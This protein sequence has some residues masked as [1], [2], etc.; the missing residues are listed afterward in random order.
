VE[1]GQEVISLHFRGLIQVAHVSPEVDLLNGVAH[2]VVVAEWT[3]LLLAVGLDIEGEARPVLHH[4]QVELAAIQIRAD[5]VEG[6]PA[7]R[8]RARQLDT[9]LVVYLVH[10]VLAERLARFAL[11]HFARNAF[12]VDAFLEA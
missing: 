1:V 11:N 2:F 5:W 12:E 4:A 9:A 3:H 10:A 7:A 6:S 8:V